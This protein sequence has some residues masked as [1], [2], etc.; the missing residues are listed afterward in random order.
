MHHYEINCFEVLA[1]AVAIGSLQCVAW[2][3]PADMPT[4]PDALLP[5]SGEVVEYW[6]DG[7]IKSERVYRDNKLLEAVYYSS[8]GSVVYE[9]CENG[10]DS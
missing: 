4:I 2:T 7:T 3:C 5:Q 8:E 10:S 6:P 1:A 9:M